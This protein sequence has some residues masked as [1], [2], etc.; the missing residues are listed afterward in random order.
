MVVFLTDSDLPAAFAAAAE[1]GFA[2]L[3]GATRLLARLLDGWQAQPTS[4]PTA[5]AAGTRR[6]SRSSGPRWL[7]VGDAAMALDPLSGS[8]MLRALEDGH[9]AAIAVD[10]WL[11][12]DSKAFAGFDRRLDAAWSE[13]ERARHRMYGLE[14]RWPWSPFWARRRAE[15]APD[16]RR[17]EAAWP[18]AQEMT[19]P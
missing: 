8:G 2:S 4:A 10:G 11:S 14:T 13:N 12:G 16:G 3:L 18:A 19:T 7:A 17:P 15:A 6:L 1:E 5:H 9:E